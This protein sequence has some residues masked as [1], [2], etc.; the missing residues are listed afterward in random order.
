M[1]EDKLISFSRE[2][3]QLGKR[4]ITLIGFLGLPAIIRT[5]K[6]FSTISDEE[7][8]TALKEM[9]RYLFLTASSDTSLFF[10]GNQL[11]DDI[12]HSFVIETAEYR[13]LC[14][15]IRPGC[16]L[17]HS[18][19]RFDTYSE[20]RSAEELNKEQ[21]SWLVSYI[22]NFGPISEES[23]SQ[24]LLAQSLSAR[25]NLD[26]DKL[27]QLAEFL[28]NEAIAQKNKSDESFNLDHFLN[29]EIT[30]SLSKI[31]SDP[32]SL[33]IALRRLLDGLNARR[34]KS[35]PLLLTNAELESVYTASTALGFTLWQH[36]AA[37]ERLVDYKEWQNKNQTLWNKI[38][39]SESLVGLGT[40]HLAHGGK[41]HLSGVATDEGFILSGNVPWTTGTGMF[42]YL[43]LAF[44]TNDARVFSIIPFPDSA[45]SDNTFK[46][47]PYQLAC[48]N[49]SSTSKIL[50]NNFLVKTEQFIFHLDK[51][52]PR[53]HRNTRYHFPEL[54]MAVA[55]LNAANNILKKST[56]PR[57]DKAKVVISDLS[58]RLSDFREK[59]EKGEVS[60]LE[61][62]FEKDELIRD[63]V[64]FLLLVSGG[65]AISAS[66]LPARLQL[67][68]MLL[69]V[70]IQDPNLI[71]KK[72][73]DTSHE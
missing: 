54:G 41:P 46:V 48:I 7:L 39:S 19:M 22:E 31:A 10:P 12:W 6:K 68:T 45:N 18:G 13:A 3:F 38:S 36:M 5:Q 47:E 32:R 70:L 24:L 42:D 52:G 4:T 2:P 15:K 71:E 40:T 20:T 73:I 35:E 33:E 27:N 66:S 56:N 64:R 25:M 59:R 37:V 63:A 53:P 58:G 67:E 23:F 17:E 69:D 61:L 57:H 29:T 1:S 8:Q 11:I 50:F 14:L 26:R 60:S 43:L 49:G 51:S 30:S 72:L 34:D 21:I 28:R 65:S 44:E 62:S 55:A 16:F 9:L